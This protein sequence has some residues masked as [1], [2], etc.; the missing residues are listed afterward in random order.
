MSGIR[1]VNSIK[2]IFL[3]WKRDVEKVT[4]ELDD[5]LSTINENTNEL[6]TNYEYLLE[7]DTK[8]QKLNER[9]DEFFIML[10]PNYRRDEAVFTSPLTKREQEVFLVL[11]GCND[12]LLTYKDISRKTGLPETMVENYVANLIMKRIPVIKMYK[13][14]R[15]YLRLDEKYRANQAKNDILKLNEAI[16]ERMF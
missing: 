4:N 7:L 9:M 2:A 11:Y 6:Q 14:M 13:N 8:I 16:A 1:I 5:H 12:S 15:T 3:P 10:N